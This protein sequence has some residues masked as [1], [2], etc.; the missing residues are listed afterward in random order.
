MGFEPENGV[1]YFIFAKII[2]AAPV[3]LTVMS[4]YGQTIMLNI[5]YS[6]HCDFMVSMIV[7]WN[8]LGS[9]TLGKLPN[10]FF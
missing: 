1:T 2:L 8:G 3:Q 4:N 5:V 9:P 10:F 7:T 6:R